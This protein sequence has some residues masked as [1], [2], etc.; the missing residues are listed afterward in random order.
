MIFNYKLSDLFLPMFNYIGDETSSTNV[1]QSAVDQRINQLIDMEDS[2]VILD[3]RAHNGRMGTQYD[4]FW[5]ECQKFLNEEEAVDDRR[6]GAITH[7]ARAISIRDF[8]DQVRQRC[9]EGTLIPSVE[10][11]RLQFWSKTPTAKKSLQHTGRFKM[12]F[13]IQQRQWRHQHI[14]SH[15]AAACYRYMREYAISLRD[16]CGFISLDD[17][18][19]VDIGEPDYPVAA[20]DRGRR[21]PVRDDEVFLVADHDFTK[22]SLIPSVAF[23]INVPEEISDSW[24]TGMLTQ[25]VIY[26]KSFYC[27]AVFFVCIEFYIGYM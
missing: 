15:Y 18:H 26:S 20:A 22:F 7:L 11:V 17:K 3:L 2:D 13:M 21:V 12:K 5:D 10:W 24:F 16:H 4:V 25:R 27:V 8:I 1:H 23:M 19:K 9:P 6:H 14:D